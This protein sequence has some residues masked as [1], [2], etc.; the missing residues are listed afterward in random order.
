MAT[1]PRATVL[2]GQ[3]RSVGR[4]AA[5][6]WCS[7]TAGR[8]ADAG[9]GSR[10]RQRP[11]R[12]SGALPDAAFVF[13]HPSIA[14]MRRELLRN[15]Q[16]RHLAGS[17]YSRGLRRCPANAP[18]PASSG[19]CSSRA[20]RRRR[21]GAGGATSGRRSIDGKELHSLPTTARSTATGGVTRLGRQGRRREGRQRQGEEQGLLVRLPAAPR[22]G[23][24]LEL[25]VPSRSRPGGRAAGGA[26]AGRRPGALRAP[27]C[28]QGLRRRQA[29]RLW[30][31]HEI[32]PVIEHCWQ[33]G[34]SSKVVEGQ[35]NVIYTFD[36]EVSCV[37]P[38]TGTERSM[39]GSAIATPSAVRRSRGAPSAKG[40]SS[41]RWARR[42]AYRSA[43]TGG[44]SPRW[45]APL[46]LEGPLRQTQRRG[47]SQQPLG[48]PVRVRRPASAGWPRC[49]CAARWHCR[50][51]AMARGRIEAGQREHLRSLTKSA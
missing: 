26:A 50:S 22:R 36:G 33:D 2:L 24:H 46:R 13:Q 47:A 23:H 39:S 40:C 12:L 37:C 21:P 41:V 29:P 8:T 51:L 18:T 49:G 35:S 11:R 45:R 27:E 6:A 43:R 44:Y 10:T 16:L 7:S 19:G 31:E 17:T 38:K 30:D 32:K 48:W 15:L 25:P 9:P 28:R 20:D 42:C 5:C 1:L 34:E 14:A 4:P 3:R